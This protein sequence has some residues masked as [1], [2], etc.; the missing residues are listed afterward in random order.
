MGTHA[1]SSNPR[2]T[3]YGICTNH[4]GQVTER[5]QVNT[6]NH[7]SGNEYV[8]VNTLIIKVGIHLTKCVKYINT[9]IIKMGTHLT[10]CVRHNTDGRQEK[11]KC[12]SEQSKT[13]TLVLLTTLLRS[14][15]TLER[16]LIMWLWE[17]LYR[18]RDIITIDP[19]KLTNH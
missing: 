15:L 3:H 5:G 8:F 6:H 2:I 18:Q 14:L 19:H 11:H 12:K 4:S 13:Y 10:K 9:L 17:E 1:P 7:T 16:V